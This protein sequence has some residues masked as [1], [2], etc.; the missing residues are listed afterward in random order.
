MGAT[1]LCGIVVCALLLPFVVATRADLGARL[2]VLA[3]IP[4]GLAMLHP[5]CWAGCSAS[6]TG[7][8][9][10]VPG[11]ASR[12]SS[13]LVFVTVDALGATAAI[14]LTRRVRPSR[15]MR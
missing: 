9:A 2:W 6:V 10:R 1:Y 14:P 5:A 11:P 8:S 4:A 3:L 13:R 12:P 15:V 7:I